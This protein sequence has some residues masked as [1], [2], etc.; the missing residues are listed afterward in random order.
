[1]SS[2]SIRTWLMS[3]SLPTLALLAVGCG[4]DDAPVTPACGDPTQVSLPNCSAGTDNFSDEACTVL[5][6]A[7]TTRATS[8]D[9]RAPS[10]TAPTE[11]QRVPR[12]TPFTFSWTAPVAARPRLR[13]PRAMT[14]ADELRRWTTLLPEAEAH[15][16]PFS[17]RAYELRFKVNGATVIRRQQSTTSWTPDARDWAI[18]VA[19]GAGR[20]VELTVYTAL[21]NNGQIGTSAGPFTPMAARRF[22][23]E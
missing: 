16:E 9:A 1:M 5:D 12:A 17:G 4:H 18:L 21:F 7:I 6:D 19:G 22:A 10:V 11:G 13:A 23:L 3:A 15:C 20:T 2:Q 8:Q 14:L